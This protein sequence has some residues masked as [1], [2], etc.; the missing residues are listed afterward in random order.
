MTA[1]RLSITLILYNSAAYLRDCIAAIRPVL[2]DG[3]AE[4]LV[5]DN[6]SPDRSVDIARAEW[7]SAQFITSPKNLGFAGGCNFVWPH[8]RG[9]YWMLL[10]PD[11]MFPHGDIR[12]MVDWMDAHPKV[13]VASPNIVGFDGRPH[14]VARRFP[15]LGRSLLEL[16]RLHWLLP[17][18]QRGRLLL[19]PYWRWGDYTDVD[20]VS[21]T[22]LMARR[23]AVEDAGLLSERFFMYGEDVEWCWRVRKA[24]WQVGLCA[25]A[26]AS[27][28][29][30]GSA[31]LTWSDDEW[32][33]RWLGS[34]YEVT[35]DLRGAAYA[36][37]LA[38][39]NAL[40][41]GIESVHPLRSRAERQEF[42]VAFH[43][44][45]RALLERRRPA[46]DGG[47]A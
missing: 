28:Q 39:V 41:M 6:A 16:S 47:R 46:S 24:G 29:V 19:G 33:R 2:E 18:R 17:A 4:L 13:G 12:R 25:G 5:L 30:A 21:G 45:S 3:T 20:W 43:Q 44:H 9:T 38:A 27:H 10:N 7:P 14:F 32:S 34:Y 31:H 40:A 23:Q 26:S 1:P 15:S 35:R 22:V 8:A 37:V 11:A 42:R 36:R